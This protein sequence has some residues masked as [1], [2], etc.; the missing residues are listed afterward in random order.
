MYPSRP[1]RG[2]RLILLLAVA[3]AVLAESASTAADL[4]PFET[5]V[6]D[7]TAFAG[8]D[9][10]SAFTRARATGAA[11]V[12]LFVTWSRV[13][14]AG[15]A[16]PAGFVA[17]NP[18]DP[19]YDWSSVD[20]QV[21]L[22]VAHGLEPLLVL[23][24]APLWAQDRSDAQ[25]NYA[26]W[27]VDA[28]EFAAFAAAAG[29]RYRGA[30]RGPPRVRYWQ[31]WNEPNLAAYLNPQYAFTG[32]RRPDGTRFMDPRRPVAVL[33]YREL[34]NA[35]ADAVHR[36][37]ADNLVVAGGLAPFSGRPSDLKWGGSTAPFRF[38]RELLCMSERPRLR[39]TCSVRVKFDVWA[40]HAYTSGD[41]S[42]SATQADDAS[43]GDLPRMKALLDAAWLHKRIAGHR[44][45]RF[46]ITEFS[47]DTAP[48]DPQGVPL[49]L[50]ARWTSEA[51]YQSWR[52]GVSLLTWFLL[53]DQPFPA[54]PYQSGL[55][56]RTNRGWGKPK[57]TLQAFRFPFVAYRR[58]AGVLTWG[59]TPAGQRAT[60]LLQQKQGERWVTLR[61]L[62][63]NKTGI[64][65]G[66]VTAGSDAP[67]RA[68]AGGETSIPFSLR[69][70][71]DRFFYPFGTRA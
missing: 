39:Q 51:L 11:V 14:P 26:D 62:T 33:R 48:P 17:T 56:R 40:H 19:A 47:W 16:K 22:A 58:G 63:P 30:D 68:A 2:P 59:R 53:R 41:A 13:A 44:R 70:P 24:S 31:A 36:V 35:F 55:W 18:D 32:P 25:W 15:S 23:L 6:A 61:R 38:M 8:S 43:L 29:T 21:T 37:H 50:Q 64:F 46:W 60:V 3:A 28:G 7:P 52:S 12:R 67:L 71:P 42:H 9:A 69:V 66:R 34:L 57:P 1:L 54:A 10:P 20:R 65:S 5:A 27:R 4:R 49:A 45:P